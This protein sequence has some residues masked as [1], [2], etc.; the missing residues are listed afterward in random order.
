MADVKISELPAVSAPAGTDLFEVSQDTGSP[1]WTSRKAT[2]A[3][4]KTF[5]T[6][7]V[8]DGSVGY[9]NSGTTN[10]LDY[11]NGHHQRWA[12]NTG[13]QTLS[14][15]NWPTSG[16]LG[17]L[18]IEGVNLGAATITWPTISWIKSDGTTTTTFASNGVTLQASG[19][20]WVLLWTRDAGTTI[21]GKIVR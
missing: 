6:N 19:I 12:P 21:Y 17:E 4:V 7:D 15:T 1:A 5:A 18:L 3:Q 10:A 8:K 2:L 13:A 9:F 14:V 11:A 20:D 16:T